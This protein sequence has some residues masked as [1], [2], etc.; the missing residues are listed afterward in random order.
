LKF[1]FKHTKKIKTKMKIYASFEFDFFGAPL[2]FAL[3]NKAI[4]I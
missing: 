2:K 3:K 1:G 4:K